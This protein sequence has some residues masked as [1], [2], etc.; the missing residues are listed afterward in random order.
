MATL[1]KAIE[2]TASVD[3]SPMWRAWRRLVRRKSAIL[4]LVIVVALI[5]LA[6]L[7]PLIAPYDPTQQ[8]YAHIRKA[9]SWRNWLGTDESGRDVLSRVIFG[10]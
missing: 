4:G 10:A 5:L 9:P 2:V 8:A 7:A 1:N 6:I 3:E